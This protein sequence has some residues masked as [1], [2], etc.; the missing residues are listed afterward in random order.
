MVLFLNKFHKFFSDRSSLGVSNKHA[1]LRVR[2]ASVETFPNS[3][4]GHFKVLSFDFEAEVILFCLGALFE[5]IEK[6]N[7]IIR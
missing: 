3:F 4:E 2:I 7:L 1:D 5:V 6:V